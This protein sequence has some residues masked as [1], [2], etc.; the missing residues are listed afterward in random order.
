MGTANQFGP[1]VAVKRKHGWKY[2]LNQKSGAEVWLGSHEALKQEVT[3]VPLA[4]QTARTDH[5]PESSAICEDDN[6]IISDFF[7]GSGWRHT[8]FWNENT[9]T[10]EAACENLMEELLAFTRPVATMNVPRP[11]NELELKEWIARGPSSKIKEPSTIKHDETI[12]DIGCGLAAT[13]RYLLKYYSP[14]VITG[15]TN[16]K[17]GLHQLRKIGLG[18]RFKYSKLP[19]LNFPKMSFDK[20]ICVEWPGKYGDRRKFFRE[21]YR[22]LNAGGQVVC[23]DIVLVNQKKDYKFKEETIYKR[24]LEEIGFDDICIKN[25]VKNTTEP[26]MRHC[27]DYFRLKCLS[28]QMGL[29]TMNKNLRFL[30]GH[31]QPVHSYL[32]ISAKKTN[33]MVGKKNRLL[34]LPALF[35]KMR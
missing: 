14:E 25:V 6:E 28:A 26:F 18:I 9:S 22:I 2:E 34:H 11:P 8:G 16:D 19:K 7:G 33:G 15:V 17:G 32:L 20:A 21:V 35:K 27:L 5:I 24:L 3:I 29:E 30:P 1:E 10:A 13:S 12:V 31:N 4:A 23:A